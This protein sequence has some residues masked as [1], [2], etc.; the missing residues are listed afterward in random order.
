MSDSSVE[1]PELSP[2]A[3]RELLAR[4]LKRRARTADRFEPFPMRDIQQ[5]Y[6][7]GRS[8][9][10][11]LGNVGA[12][13]YLEFEAPRLDLARLG[14]ALN[15]LIRRHDMLRAVILPGGQQQILQDV[16]PYDVAVLDLSLQPPDAVASELDALRTRLSHRVFPTDRWPLFDLRATLVP[17]N[18]MRIH[19]GIDLL[20]ADLRSIYILL[21][22]WFQLY[23]DP[24]AALPPLGISFRDYVLKERSLEDA[25]EFA[26]AEAYWL[27]RIPK[28]PS[29]P[30]LPL[31]KNPASITSPRFTRRGARFSPDLWAQ[32]RAKAEQHHVTPASV[33][34]A[35]FGRTLASWSRSP[36]LTVDV[37]VFNRQPFHRDVNHLVG[38]FTSVVLVGL[39]QSEPESFALRCERVNRELWEALDHR[40]FSGVRVLRELLRRTGGLGRAIMPVVFTCDLRHDMVSVKESASRMVPGELVYGVSQ[41]P[42]VF[43]DHQVLEDSGGLTIN[44]DAVADLFPEGLLDEMLAANM[45]LLEDL[46]LSDRPWSDAAGSLT[47]A[48][49]RELAAAANVTEA[50]VST[51]LLHELFARQVSRDP[52]KIAVVAGGQS[53]TYG[54]LFARANHIGRRLRES[55]A[56]PNS[57]VGVVME[58]GWEQIVAVLGILQAGSAYLPVDPDLPPERLGYMLMQGQI[59]IAL[60]QSRVDAGVQ[61]PGD[62]ERI[63]V[64]GIEWPGAEAAPLASAQK[65]DD[66]AYVIYTS[67]STGLPK[68]VMIDHRGA[69]NTI[70]DINE[71]FSIGP[72]DRVLALSSLSF[73]LSVYDIFGTLAAGATIVVPDVS[74][75]ADPAVWAETIRREGI[76]VWNSV[77]AM[78]E[79]LVDYAAGRNDGATDAL[80]LVLMSGD[81]VP[82]TLPD[83]IKTLIDGVTVVSLGGATE[84]SIWSILY[85]IEQTAPDWESIPYGTPMR[86]QH[87]YVLDGWLDQRPVGVPGELYLGGIGLAKGYWGDQEKTAARFIVHPR[88]RER[89]YRTGDWG[90]Y[91]PDGNIRFL[92]REDFQV[93]IQGYRVELGEIEA[94]LR[95]HPNVRSAVATAAGE[96]RGPKRLLAHIVCHSEPGPAEQD[97]K[98]FLRGKLPSYMVPASIV[99]LDAL[100]LTANGKVDRS[101]LPSAAPA[102]QHLQGPETP[103]AKRLNALITGALRV[104][105]VDMNAN[106]TELGA[107]SLDAL[108]IGNLLEREFGFR[109]TMQE[110]FRF[111]TLQGLANYYEQ[112]LAGSEGG[113][114]SDAGA[115]QQGVDGGPESLWR[116]FR[117]LI[118]PRERMAFKKRQP[119]LR[120]VEASGLLPLSLPDVPP[121]PEVP[122]VERRS[123]RT[124]GQE[125]IP[126]EQFGAFLGH[127]RQAC[128]GQ[129]RRQYASAGGLYPV[130]TYLHVKRDRIDGV[131]EGTYYYDPQHH[132]VVPLSGNVALDRNIHWS[133]NRL[134]FDEAAFSVFLVSQLSAIAPL[135]QEKSLHFATLEAGLISQLLEMSAPA[136]QLGLCH[137][138]DLDFE[139]VRR[140]FALDASHVLVHS[141]L[142][143]AVDRTR[144]PLGEESE[145]PTV[146]GAGVL[147]PVNV[148]D[149]SADVILDPVIRAD[150]PAV[151]AE[152]PSRMLLTGATGFLGAFLLQELLERTAA[153]IYCLVRAS[154]PA[155]GMARLRRNLERYALWDER[156]SARIVPVLGDLAEPAL[157]LDAG[158]FD[159]LAERM[160]AIY[161]NGAHVNLILPYSELKASNVGGT[162]EVLRLASRSRTKPVHF[163]SSVAVFPFDG[164]NVRREDDPLDHGEGLIGGY[165]QSKWVAEQLVALAR[166]RGIPVTVYRPGTIAGHSDSGIFSSDSYLN[167]LIRGCIELGSAPDVDASVDMVPVD[168]VARAIVALSQRPESLSKVFHLA[169]PHPIPM[170]GLIDF[171]QTFGY[172]VRRV[173]YESWK[174]ELLSLGEHFED[175]ALFPYGAV[176]AQLAGASMMGP[177]YDCAATV[178]ALEGTSVVCPEVDDRLLRVYFSRYVSSGL[179]EPTHVSHPPGA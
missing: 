7:I 159:D 73:D 39:D 14:A 41:T 156:V 121:T 140:L 100:P 68:G 152:T 108:R 71:R 163:V 162:H 105:R 61:W 173:P 37:T 53:I 63:C 50:P 34:L 148:A 65:P 91:S 3:K 72:G 38:D 18:R 90:V 67:G 109:P 82:V 168:Y 133:E 85:P 113:N 80:R 10:F 89:L 69:V 78:M 110:F 118:D 94:A 58:K 55:G 123:H 88:T 142:G 35:A 25:E 96:P 171:M 130:Q 104:D 83:R 157:G 114:G 70:L 79:M 154:T 158:T 54:D 12:Y 36:R 57:L 49:H 106:L 20:I 62:I 22:E 178:R 40:H 30:D 139:P 77:P 151:V 86:N 64:D 164:G 167:N 115:A 92:G 46:A 126:L 32:L 16:A 45:R 81:W 95:Q 21:S 102:L 74:D 8:Q 76:T 99:K 103:I 93:K 84:A 166:S 15:Q 98:N 138:G 134:I 116:S 132:R 23:V 149:L 145:D 52:E 17:G 165:A 175:N 33:L 101:A 136:C 161:H 111:P 5:A 155:E 29:A 144:G 48:S 6:W 179:L 112:R 135:Y 51:D 43:L 27:E 125:P 60:T 31:A 13:V 11:E 160:D 9:D 147:T 19:V 137:I 174:A 143:G 131:S 2:Q 124:F 87:V 119:G 4:L 66:L 42:Q 44:W 28:L 176:I 122:G 97:L 1:T 47:P 141:L 24:R 177:Q 120:P 153:D 170:N 59:R 117:L 129:T 150:G 107:N 26:R 172:N 56:G 75:K 128:G 127:L 146:A 169:N